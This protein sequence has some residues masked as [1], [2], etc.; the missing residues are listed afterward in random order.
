LAAAHLKRTFSIFGYRAICAHK[1][2][3]LRPILTISSPLHE[4]T[5]PTG[6]PCGAISGLLQERQRWIVRRMYA[7]PAAVATIPDPTSKYYAMLRC[8]IGRDVSFITTANPSSTIKLIETG[9]QHVEQMIRD[10]ADGTFTPPGAVDDN[11]RQAVRFKPN[12]HL[13]K[14]LEEGVRRDGVLMPRHFWNVA[15][16]C[17]WTG[18]TVG[19]YLPRLRELFDDIPIRDIGLVASEGRFSIPLADGTAAGVAEITSN[20][21]EFI[22]A[23]AYEQDQPPTLRAHELHV[24]AEYFLVVTNFAGLWRYNMDDRIRVVDRMGR[25]PVFEFLSRGR[26]TANITGEKIT[27]HQVIEAMRAAAAQTGHT[28]NRFVMQGHFAQTPYYELRAEADHAH[29][30][31]Q[32]AAALDRAL[33]ELNIEYAAKRKSGRLGDIRPVA[34]PP[35]AL[36]QVELNT[37]RQ[38]HGRSEQY[39]HCYLLTDVLTDT[40]S[41]GA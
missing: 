31:D 30:L 32:L 14:R 36:E 29:D 41:A 38:R 35:G 21:L 8:S 13:A 25:S 15:F 19:L 16:L 37:I 10:V 39:K 26:H 33:A 40:P 20:F 11:V 4:Q 7:I 1:S 3:W 17:N 27:E 34:L 6:L 23:E 28:I 22:P 9:Q 18:G 24:G 2:V 12:R 5:S